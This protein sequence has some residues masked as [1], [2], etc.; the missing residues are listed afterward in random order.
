[1]SALRPDLRLLPAGERGALFLSI[2]CGGLAG[3]LAVLQ[4]FLLSRGIAG[5]F[6]HGADLAGTGPLLLGL[7]AAALARAAA[8]AGGD[9]LAQ[10]GASHSKAT[11]RVRLARR[12]V[13]LGPRFSSGERTGELVQTIAAGVETLEPY[14]AQLLPQLA[15]AVLVP[16][17][18]LVAVLAAELGGER[19]VEVPGVD[20]E[21]APR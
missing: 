16:A 6:L 3:G 8:S 20:D 19:S 7:G 9:V 1:M 21:G 11:L 10:R 15:L 12:L 4:A 5:A 13:E 17:V 2:G 18:V 14:L